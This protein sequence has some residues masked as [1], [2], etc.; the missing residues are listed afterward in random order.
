MDP[1]IGLREVVPNQTLPERCK[2]FT[3]STGKDA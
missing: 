3:I 1:P 2:D